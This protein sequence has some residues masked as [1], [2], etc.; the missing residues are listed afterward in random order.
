MHR[1]I[2]HSWDIQST[3][4]QQL[5][6]AL[7]DYLVEQ[8]RLLPDNFDRSEVWRMLDVACGTGQWVRDVARSYP[9]IEVVGLDSNVEVIGYARMLA[10]TSRLENAAFVPGD[11]FA[12]REIRDNCF[13]VVHARFLA[14]AVQTRLWPVVLQEL[15]RVCRPGGTIIWTEATFPTTNSRACCQWCALTQEAI[16]RSGYTANVTSYMERLVNDTGCCHV[17]RRETSIDIAAGSAFN[18]RT[19]RDVVTLLSLLEPFLASVHGCNGEQITDLCRD[20]I[21]DLYDEAFK[22]EWVLKTVTCE[23]AEIEP[24]L[25]H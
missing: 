6:R 13:D 9:D 15:V 17:Q 24:Y 21:I 10:T 18:Q 25:L 3:L 11:M 20:A 5:F 19:Y 7:Q 12:M 8:R 22:G 1:V 23:K 16:T 4:E 2:E 14:L